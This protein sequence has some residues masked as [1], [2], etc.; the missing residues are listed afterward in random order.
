MGNGFWDAFAS[1]AMFYMA[2]KVWVSGGPVWLWAGCA[3]MCVVHFVFAYKNR[4]L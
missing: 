3:L 2:L 1:G 4:G